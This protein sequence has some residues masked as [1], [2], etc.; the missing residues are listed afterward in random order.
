MDVVLFP[1]AEYYWFYG[2]FVAFVLAM[3][4]LDLGVFHRKS[5]AVSVVE[6]GVWT[7]VWIS[8]ALLFNVGLYF[9]ARSSFAGN[10]ELLAL[11][12]FSSDAAARQVA[13]EFLTGFLIEK[14]LAVDNIF[15]F[16]I[17]FSYFA[18][19]PALQHRVLFYGI[20]GALAFRAVF[21][22]LGAFLMQIHWV[23]VLAGLF[24]IGTGIKLM[25]TPDT[26]MDPEQ[27]PVVRLA[28]RFLPLTG[29]LHGDSFF[30]REG[31]VLV[32]T[33]LLLALLVVEF[34]DVVFA[35]DS[36]PAIFAVTDEPLLV[37]TSNIF[38]ILGLRSLY[39]T[40]AGVMDRFHLLKY[41]LAT[42]LVFVGLKMAWLNNA[43]GGKF[44]VVASLA[45]IGGILVV[46]AVASWAI[47]KRGGA[48]EGRPAL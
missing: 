40:L 26:P 5:H 47:P 29:K 3:L 42:I 24:L 14:A 32:G 15:V 6:S 44:P 36:V 13:L 30:V 2:A 22:A 11:P 35:V 19:P 21:I 28:R 38:A 12:G 23:V 17:V 48:G 4:A 37:F 43:F 7:A 34:T 10:P 18:I 16:A 46:S 9:W 33:P 20:L 41:G 31:G 39:F 25:F 1:F 27:N 45:I 8:L